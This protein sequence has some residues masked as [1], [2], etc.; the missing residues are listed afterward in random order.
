MFKQEK[1][2]LIFMSLVYALIGYNIKQPTMQSLGLMGWLGMAQL[3]YCI[4]SWIKRGNQFISPYIIF[5]LSLY[6]FSYGQSFLW[7][8]GLDSERTLVDFRGVTIPEIFSAQVQAIIMLAF[9]HI[10]ATY[11]LTKNRQRSSYE[12]LSVDNSIRLKRIGWFLFV[13]SVI[14][15]ITDTISKLILS[16]TM[17]YGAI[18]EREEAIGLD[19]LSAIIADYCIPSVICLFI[20]Y[21]DNKVVRNIIVTFL[22]LNIVAIMIIGGRSNAV[23]LLA[24]L[25]ILYNYL[26]KR[27]TRKWLLLGAVGAF[28]LLQVLAFVGNVRGDGLKSA[29]KEGFQ[30]E[31]NAVVD[32]IAE[33]GGTM[34]CQIKT[35]NLVPQLEPYRYGKSYLFAFTTIIPNLGFWDI[36]PAKKESNLG[37]WLT[38]K[39]GLSYGTG[40]SMCAEAYA[41][42]GYLGFIVFFF[43]GWFLASIFG[44]IEIS[45][46]TRN[47]ALM[48]FLLILFWFFLKIPRNSFINIV[49]PIFFIA[50]PI[51]L[52][53]NNFKLKRQ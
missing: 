44:K 39:L 35:M 51:Y 46:N 41:N 25:V 14:P 43:W 47:Y 30:V 38:A 22:L 11:Y 37:D 53:C 29:S 52:Y 16:A 48:A 33:M 24:I 34:F 10:G 8:F 32:A 20:A 17:G 5:L 23:I 26:V 6:V 42:F 40:F 49:R 21:K 28:F 7:A 13:V 27:F 19:N 12:Q 15:Y 2:I 3:L 4:I 1:V 50:G 18:Y 36:H 45:A 9:F 31:N